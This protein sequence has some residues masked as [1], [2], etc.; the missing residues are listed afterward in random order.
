MGP[1]KFKKLMRETL[2]SQEKLRSTGG[3]DLPLS[4]LACPPGRTIPTVTQWPAL[5]A[6]MGLEQPMVNSVYG[7]VLR[8][9]D[10]KTCCERALNHILTE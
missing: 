6:L 5:K 4:L 1:V 8:F 3:V 10:R 7:A 2:V 9:L